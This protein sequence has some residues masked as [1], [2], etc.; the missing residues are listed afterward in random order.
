MEID[1]LNQVIMWE[2]GTTLGNALTSDCALSAT[3]VS[4]ARA[5]LRWVELARRLL[6]ALRTLLGQ[7]LC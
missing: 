2:D 1:Y 7:A 6:R 4:A 5:R 3:I